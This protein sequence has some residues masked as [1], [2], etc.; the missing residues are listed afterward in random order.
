[1]LVKLFG[2][3]PGKL[4]GQRRKAPRTEPVLNAA[5]KA[6]LPGVH[7]AALVEPP[8]GA[9]SVLLLMLVIVLAAIGW[10]AFA[11]V[12][13]ISRA[14]GRVVPDGREQIVASLEGG[15]LRELHVREG[16][17]VEAGQELALLDPTRFEAQQAEG[18]ARR[19]ALQAALA[20]LDAEANGRTLRFPDEVVDA[21]SAV[22][23]ETEAHHARKRL[24]DEATSASRRGIALLQREL[25][26]AESM[27]A[28][29]L[30]SQVEVMRL[31]RQLNELQLQVQERQNRFRQ[32]ASTELARVRSELA[33]LQEQLVVR[34]DALQRTVLKSPVRGLVKNIRVGTLGGVVGPGA[35]IMEIVPLGPRVLV[36]ARIRPAEIGFV[37]VGQTV[38]IKLSAYD[39]ATYGGLKGVIEYISP[40]ALGD[41]ERASSADATYYRALIRADPSTLKAAGEPLPVLPGMTGT[42]EVRTG[43]RTVLAFLLR[44]ALKS[45]EAFP[46]R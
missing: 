39:F 46:E 5:E 37:R 18:D 30:M 11:R 7:A 36:E 25:T 17:Q 6:L 32:E 3:L 19:L 44:P 21:T 12:D 24:L 23:A 14:E 42:V 45:R 8:R 28:K 9:R 38:Q 4:F 10:A 1:M 22:Q 33:Q 26:I 20:R 40:D 35:P 15:I 31:Q 2:K 43:E 27:A 34:A 29:G 13:K 16:M 41:P